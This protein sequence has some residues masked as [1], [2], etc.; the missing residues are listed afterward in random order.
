V[1]HGARNLWSMP[2]LL[3]A[4]LVVPVVLTHCYNGPIRLA[5]VDSQ[6]GHS[7]PVGAHNGGVMLDGTTI[8]CCIYVKS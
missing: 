8:C 5:L 6:M 4:G 3:S 1:N 7:F 2:V